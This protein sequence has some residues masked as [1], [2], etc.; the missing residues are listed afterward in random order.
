MIQ[1]CNALYQQL[2]NELQWYASQ[3]Y[4]FLLE[5]EYFFHTAEKFRRQLRLE[6]TGYHFNNVQDEIHFF[7]FIKPKF[8]AESEYAGLL[9]FAGNFCPSA[10]DVHYAIN[11]WTR[12]AA[13]LNKF[14]VMNEEFY[15]YHL[16]G[17]FDLDEILFTRALPCEPESAGDK[18][19]YDYDILSGKLIAEFRYRDY[20]RFQLKKLKRE[21]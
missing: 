6:L 3:G 12:Q 21:N 7:K 4:P 5:T 9:N 10:S 2:V 14:Q 15:S 17:R 1:R 18:T 8:V 13:R 20:S 19:T 16:N 11:F